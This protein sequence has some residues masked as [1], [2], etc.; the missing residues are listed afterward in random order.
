MLHEIERV[1]RVHLGYP[2]LLA[3]LL[4]LISPKSL[5]AE[6]VT[7]TGT[8]EA[9]DAA[10]RT[11]TVRRK[12]AGG[13]KMRSFTIAATAEIL[14]GGAP[15]DIGR[16]RPGQKVEI[17]YDTTAKQ[18]T[19]L[20]AQPLDP[21]ADNVP[22]QGFVALFN[23]KDLSGWRGV[24]RPPFDNPAKRAGAPRAQLA[25]A[26]VYQVPSHASGDIRVI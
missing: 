21:V 25:A 17:T 12:T 9:V 15:A 19:K 22:P 11:I 7:A 23:G 1:I 4:V 3:G 2:W 20:N 18:V 24:L 16:F 14:L 13:D 26:R 6:T 5:N 8:V 10:A